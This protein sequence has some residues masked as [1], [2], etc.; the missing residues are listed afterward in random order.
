MAQAGL[1]EGQKTQVKNAPE[2]A[3]ASSSSSRGPER[4]PT[5][6][7]EHRPGEADCDLLWQEAREEKSREARQQRRLQQADAQERKEK[8]LKE[9]QAGDRRAPRAPVGLKE[10]HKKKNQAHLPTCTNRARRMQKNTQSKAASQT[11]RRMQ[12]KR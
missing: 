11:G 9:G 8:G 4:R 6:V 12:T 5:F 1:K 7:P 10:G 3:A 2:G